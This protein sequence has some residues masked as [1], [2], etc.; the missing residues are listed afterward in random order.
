[1]FE[2]G[3]TILVTSWEN[4]GDNY[5]TTTFSGLTAEDVKFYKFI[6]KH[7]ESD[8][9]HEQ[10]EENFFIVANDT[11]GDTPTSGL[12]DLYLKAIELFPNTSDKIPTYDGYIPSDDECKNFDKYCRAAWTMKPEQKPTTELYKFANFISNMLG[13]LLESPSE[14]YYECHNYFRVFEKMRI[15]YFEKSAIDKTADFE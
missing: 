6:L 4:D 2:A 9:Y 8:G 7:F 3:Y 5:K 11:H 10:K 12:R 15:Y 13:R 14:H 1:M